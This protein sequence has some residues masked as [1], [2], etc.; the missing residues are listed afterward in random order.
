MNIN[1]VTLRVANE[2]EL[3]IG[4]LYTHAADTFKLLLGPLS[5][6]I[7]NTR[8]AGWAYFTVIDGVFYSART[9]HDL[10]RAITEEDEL[11]Q[12]QLQFGTPVANFLEAVWSNNIDEVLS[13]DNKTLNTEVLAIMAEKF[14]PWQSACNYFDDNYNQG[15][16]WQ[17]LTDY[18][19][20]PGDTLNLLQEWDVE[21][22]QDRADAWEVDRCIALSR[23]TNHYFTV[24]M[25]MHS[26]PKHSLHAKGSAF[27]AFMENYD[28]LRD[29]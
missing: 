4:R 10:L 9:G 3:T 28:R 19:Y 12:R 20:S 6:D 26:D 25:M 11:I 18:E 22:M 17:Y 7:L 13:N 15:L 1:E 14:I 29:A 23:L 16:I 27:A 21:E 5:L 24:A 8:T 2:P